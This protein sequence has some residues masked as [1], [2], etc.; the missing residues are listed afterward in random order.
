MKISRRLGFG[1]AI[2]AVIQAYLWMFEVIKLDT[3][4]SGFYD[5]KLFT[6]LQVG[7]TKQIHLRV[8]DDIIDV[9]M[10]GGGQEVVL[11]WTNPDTGNMRWAV[12]VGLVDAKHRT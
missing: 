6:L 9:W 8:P 7:A 3:I 2:F 10:F 11:E 5:Y 12:E 4:E 1:L